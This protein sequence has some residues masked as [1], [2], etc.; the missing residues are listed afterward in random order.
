MPSPQD[1]QEQIRQQ[2]LIGAGVPAQSQTFHPMAAGGN[3][4]PFVP[5]APF[6]VA[7]AQN[8]VR[9]REA[10]INMG[11]LSLLSISFSLML[12][13]A[14]TFLGGFLMG[15]WVAGTT[16]T[17]TMNYA[18]PS[19][20]YPPT[21]AYPQERREL[22]NYEQ[23]MGR[24]LGTATES[25]I[26]DTEIRGVPTILSP[27]IKATQSEIGKQVGGRTEE[28]LK[29][30]FVAP[31]PYPQP[32]YSA[33]PVSPY[34][35]Q[36]PERPSERPA[37][38]PVVTSQNGAAADSLPVSYSPAAQDNDG[39]FTVQLGVYASQENANGLVNHIRALGYPSQVTSG[40]APD[41]AKCIM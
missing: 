3:Y 8:N 17:P 28:Y 11:K 4:V 34:S 29:Q 16:V 37:H 26:K 1:I 35:P 27:L 32:Q 19:P 21:T 41:G 23:N 14:F 5:Q 2:Q 40:K 20:Y 33:P 24:Q 30:Q 9:P 7:N 39:G 38:L 36:S 10:P 22:S 15:I 18:P 31:Q 13:G 25:A 12:L 6:Q